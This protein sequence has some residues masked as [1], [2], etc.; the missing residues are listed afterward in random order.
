MLTDNAIK[1]LKPAKKA[2]RSFDT[3]GLYIEVSP[4]GGKWWRLKYRFAGKEK[5]L[6]LGVYPEITLKKAR[7]LRDQQRRLIAEGIDPSENRLDVPL[8]DWPDRLMVGCVDHH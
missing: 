5:R 8:A 1:N 4:A 2:L 3:Q 6:S 7:E